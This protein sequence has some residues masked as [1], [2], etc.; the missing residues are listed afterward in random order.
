MGEMVRALVSLA[1]FCFVAGCASVDVNYSEMSFDAF[2]DAQNLGADLKDDA[3]RKWSHRVKWSSAELSFD[4][5]ITTRFSRWCL[6]HDGSTVPFPIV[7]DGKFIPLPGGEWP[8]VP[9]GP[10]GT[11]HTMVSQFGMGCVY[12]N[13]TFLGGVAVFN[14]KSVSF[15]SGH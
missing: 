3:I 7:V 1:T 14:D 6:L 11:T 9:A 10:V 4:D 5:S 15:Y 13:K 12:K 8:N 2:I